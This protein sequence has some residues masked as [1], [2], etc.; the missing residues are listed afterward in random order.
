[1]AGRRRRGTPTHFL[2]ERAPGSATLDRDAALAELARR[3]YRSHGPATEKELARWATLTLSD[4]RRAIDMLG[5][6]VVRIEVEDRTMYAIGAPPTRSPN[7]PR[8]MLLQLLDEYVGGYGETRGLID[9]CGRT[10][11]PPGGGDH[12]FEVVV[13]DG[14]VVGN[15]RPSRTKG[16]GPVEPPPCGAGTGGTP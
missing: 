4:V 9:P 11:V 16:C 6:E 14:V 1:M 12:F 2:D 5:D 3:F 15:W 13:L 10:Q 8:A 7:A